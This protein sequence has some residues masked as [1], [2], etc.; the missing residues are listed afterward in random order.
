MREDIFIAGVI[1]DE[2]EL[3]EVLN[4]VWKSIRQSTVVSLDA[5]LAGRMK[6]DNDSELTR[7]R[8]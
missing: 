6:V 7:Y 5:S 1:E 3:R 2:N 8:L 4:R